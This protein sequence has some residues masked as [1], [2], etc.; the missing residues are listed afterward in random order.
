MLASEQKKLL[1]YFSKACSAREMDGQ[2]LED[3]SIFAMLMYGHKQC[4][5]LCVK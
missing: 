1:S 2:E 4:G 3:T 5:I